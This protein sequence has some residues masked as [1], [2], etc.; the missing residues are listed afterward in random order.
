[1]FTKNVFSID[2][3]FSAI[4]LGCRSFSGKHYWSTYDEAGSI[5]TINTALGCGVNVFDVSPTYGNGHAES[6]LGK[7]LYASKK[8]GSVF[9]ITKCGII[10]EKNNKIRIDLSRE[11]ILKSIDESLKRLKTTYVDLYSCHFPDPNTDIEETMETLVFLK[12]L[13]KIRYIGFTNFSESETRRALRVAKVN[14]VQGLYNLIERNPR[15]VYNSALSYLV[16]K[17]LFPLCREESMAFFPYSPLFHGV[18]TD[19][20]R[21][22]LYGNTDI[23]KDDPKLSNERLRAYLS[24]L[25]K[26]EALAKELGKTVSQIAINFLIQKDTVTSVLAGASNPSQLISNL[27]AVNFMLGPDELDLIDK[28]VRE[29]SLSTGDIFQTV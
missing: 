14:A 11:S 26:L 3:D 12:K 8:R 24:L 1:M 7:T 10:L 21:R 22:H 28:Y 6:L 13:G 5:Q 27:H 17:D 23:R 18:L 2:Y 25:E 15:Y 20:Y 29:F 19:N 4:G 9:L 16:E